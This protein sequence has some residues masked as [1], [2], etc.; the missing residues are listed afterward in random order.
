MNVTIFLLAFK[1][2]GWAVVTVLLVMALIELN[3]SPKP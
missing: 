3:K 2:V 1:A